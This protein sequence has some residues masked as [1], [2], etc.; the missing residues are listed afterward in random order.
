MSFAACNVLNLPSRQLQAALACSTEERFAG[1][2]KI[3]SR[4]EG[5][6]NVSYRGDED[7]GL[8]P[9]SSRNFVSNAVKKVLPS[10]VRV[11][12]SSG[13]GSGSSTAGE[14]KAAGFIVGSDGIIVTNR[15]VVAT[16][17]S[18]VE[19]S[20]VVLVTFQDGVTLPATILAISESYDICF[21]KVVDNQPTPIPPNNDN[22]DNISK[23]TSAIS[24]TADPHPFPTAPIGNGNDVQLGDWMIA[25]GSPAE[26]DNFVT[27]GIA[28]TI[29]RP[30]NP[31]VNSRSKLILDRSATFIGTDALFN[32]GISGGPLLD[33]KGNVVG[34]CTYLREDLNGLGFAIAINRVVDAA[35]ELLD[36]RDIT[37]MTNDGRE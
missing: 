30:P 37:V 19:S 28:S 7:N 15:H 29:Q 4:V 23:T 2:G 3:L 21:L 1:V 34:M 8:V 22:N 9:S 18:G 14:H 27:L 26:F 36:G 11:E 24:P 35:H 17:D 16:A 12:L 6:N 5:W 31:T 33:D 32:K 13:G 25:V 20:A 10:V